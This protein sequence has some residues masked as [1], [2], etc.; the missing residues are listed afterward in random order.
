MRAK[1]NSELSFGLGT[2]SG[3]SKPGGKRPEAFRKAQQSGSERPSSD[4]RNG[5]R[6]WWTASPRLPLHSA[7]PPTRSTRGRRV[8]WRCDRGRGRPG[9]APSSPEIGLH[10]GLGDHLF[11]SAWV[12][13]TRFLYGAC[14]HRE[15]SLQHREEQG[16][17]VREILVQCP[18]RN[19]C[20]ARHAR[21]VQANQTIA[22][23]NLNGRLENSVHGGDG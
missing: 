12:F 22:Q 18:Y 10:N 17:L 20:T 15:V 21:G 6:R 1:Y 13:D 8:P 16:L 3:G 11:R 5:H 19:A 7:E 14:Q 2:I 4:W 23:Q 9:L